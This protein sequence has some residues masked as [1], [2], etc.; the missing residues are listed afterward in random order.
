[1]MIHVDRPAPARS[2]HRLGVSSWVN[3]W[4]V[5]ELE[6]RHEDGWIRLTGADPAG[7]PRVLAHV[8]DDRIVADGSRVERT[9]AEG[10]SRWAHT[11]AGK[12]QEVY[13]SGDRLLVTTSSLDY[14]AWGFLG[15]ALLLDLD[16][17][18]LV[19]ELRGNR[20]AGVGGGRFVVGLEGYGVFD[21]WL[22]DR[23]GTV[24]TSWRSYGH[25]VADP[26][27]T[28]RVV[29]CDRSTPT[30]SRVVRLL[31]DGAIERGPRL[32]D[33][34]SPSP[35]TLDDDTI[36]VLDAGVLRVVDRGLHDWTLAELMPIPSEQTWRFFGELRLDGDRL[37][38]AIAERS[39]DPPL[40][41]T[42]H[43]WTFT[44]TRHRPPG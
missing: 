32:V 5:R 19:A 41:Y 1:M 22:H 4:R 29:E 24:L 34:Q 16:R 6:R 28:V 38:V 33:S 39:S 37:T 44:L 15:P 18:T 36:V 40:T 10:R 21:T 11:C 35:V 17:G 2:H 9:D 43:R 23:D 31:L 20:G 25:Y 7:D 13:V 30:D 3:S 12:P 14:H 26:D 27:G 42:T 8:G